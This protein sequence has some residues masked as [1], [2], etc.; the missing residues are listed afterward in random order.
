MDGVPG[1]IK[2]GIIPKNSVLVRLIEKVAALVEELNPLGE[3]EKAMS[4]SARNI[5]LILL[6]GRKEDDSGFAEVR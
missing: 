5:N 1:N 2:T 3:S 6:F 4:E